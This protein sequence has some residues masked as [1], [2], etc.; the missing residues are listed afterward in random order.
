MALLSFASTFLS[1]TL[2]AFRRSA[3]SIRRFGSSFR[4]SV[5]SILRF[6]F[7]IRRFDCFPALCPFY[8]SLLLL[9]VALPFLS[10]ASA[11]IRRSGS[12]FLRF[13]FSIRRFGP[14]FLRF[15]FSIRHFGCLPSLQLFFLPFS[16]L[17]HHFSSFMIKT[18]KK[19]L[20]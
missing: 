9:F 19:R 18:I 8:P 5:L 14:S 17:I 3:L 11:F 12:S 4:R 16:L 1:V 20:L 2:T 15:A 6:T 10:V 7:S 13:A